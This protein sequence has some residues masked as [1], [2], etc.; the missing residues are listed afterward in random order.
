MTAL[1]RSTFTAFAI[2]IHLL[3]LEMMRG[4]HI[5]LAQIRRYQQSP[6]NYGIRTLFQIVVMLSSKISQNIV[7]AWK[8]KRRNY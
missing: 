7:Y 2:I 8:T 5:A 1:M 6:G 4:F 3:A